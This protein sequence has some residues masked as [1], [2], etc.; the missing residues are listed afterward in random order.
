[1]ANDPSMTELRDQATALGVANVGSY[2]SKTDLSDAIAARETELARVGATAPADQ[3]SSE[4]Q[5]TIDE[6]RTRLAALESAQ[7]APAAD[8]DKARK[9]AAKA[10][11][12]WPRRG[13]DGPPPWEVARLHAEDRHHGDV[14]E[15]YTG[16]GAVTH[17]MPP[18]TFGAAGDDVREL[19]RLLY[20]LGYRS[21]SVVADPAS[22]PNAV[23]DNSVMNDVRSF[24][25]AHGV[26]ND[27]REFAGLAVPAEDLQGRV[28][29]PYIWQALYAAADRHEREL[30][31]A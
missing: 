2:R 29:G 7:P 5:R 18:L 9:D 28:V 21:N 26:E 11:A 22:N 3:T 4:Q 25:S 30:A 6:L 10:F 27:P 16:P 14:P 1:M 15:P 23:L 17:R 12:G 8:P 24:A 20:V 31:T 13:Y 19:V